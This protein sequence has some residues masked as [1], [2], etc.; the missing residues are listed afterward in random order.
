M[1]V[2]LPG[3]PFPIPEEPPPPAAEPPPPAPPPWKPGGWNDPRGVYDR[4]GPKSFRWGPIAV[5]GTLFLL[6]GGVLVWLFL[7]PS[8]PP[9]PAVVAVALWKYEDP[10]RPV[11][12]WAQRDAFRLV[13]CFPADEARPE[14]P[15]GEETTFQFATDLRSFA[16]RL[17]TRPPDRPFICYLTAIAAPTPSGVAVLA[18]VPGGETDLTVKE[19]L[20]QMKDCPAKEKL[21]VFDVARP[22]DRPILGPFRTDP[23]EALHDAITAYG[24]LPCPVMVACSRGEVSQPMD[25]EGTSA[26]A[27]YLVEGLRGAADGSD[28]SAPG[29]NG[30]VTLREWYRFTARRT[31][32]WAKQVRD[33]VQTPWLYEAGSGEVNFTV[34]IPSAFPAPGEDAAFTNPMPRELAEAWV[35]RDGRIADRLIRHPLALAAE[36]GI[37]LRA[38]AYWRAGDA[39]RCKTELKQP[40]LTHWLEALPPAP[41]AAAWTYPTLFR[42]IP[43]R[44]AAA[45]PKEQDRRDK[46]DAELREAVMAY[47]R[48]LTAKSDKEPDL[49]SERDALIAKAE[50]VTVP[51][52]RLVWEKLRG[53]PAPSARVVKDAAALIDGLL[54]K[55]GDVAEQTLL[56]TLSTVPDDRRI[57]PT[58]V[59]E[60]LAAEEAAGRALAVALGDAYPAVVQSLADADQLKR[61]VETALFL[62]PELSRRETQ[63]AIESLKQVASIFNDVRI[64]AEAVAGTRAAVRSA[65]WLLTATAGAAGEDEDWLKDWQTLAR[66]TGLAAEKVFAASLPTI[67]SDEWRGLGERVAGDSAVLKKRLA[68]AVALAK[69]LAKEEAPAVADVTKLRTALLMSAPTAMEK[70]LLWDAVDAAEGVL[71]KKL[72]EGPDATETAAEKGSPQAKPAMPEPANFTRVA[73]NRVVVSLTLA[74]LGGLDPAKLEPG[75]QGRVKTDPAAWAAF[76]DDVR[77]GWSEPAVSKK[78][79]TL[80]RATD[81]IPAAERATRATPPQAAGLFQPEKFPKQVPAHLLVRSNARTV[82]GWLAEHFREYQKLRP[83]G[84]DFYAAQLRAS[85]ERARLSAD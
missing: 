54:K 28:D 41:V 62:G 19:L 14:S 75:W 12:P 59:P 11:N 1:A 21:L 8:A 67:S 66:S 2:D 65:L 78:V 69:K 60:L 43:N 48:K 23:A 36:E 58:A 37:L 27:F 24:P 7:V 49:S 46:A 70:K 61:K 17:K 56:R 18:P 84:S 39:E 34:F 76:G 72:R 3:A 50:G 32:R 42:P 40:Q 57:D 68:D 5:F 79:D 35:A 16:G 73:S 44:P 25:P 82:E 20:D 74:R 52:A 10:T 4:D 83:R 47:W 30:R 51:T 81:T 55:D 38:E 31:A 26:F 15:A 29:K 45:D 22:L 77:A 80:L 9:R 85:A 71:H 53:E 64:R 13:A 63:E 6:L 33:Q